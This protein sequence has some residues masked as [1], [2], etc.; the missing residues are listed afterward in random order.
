M[1]SHLSILLGVQWELIFI[2]IRTSRQALPLSAVCLP[3][4]RSVLTYDGRL[5]WSRSV[6]R[7][8]AVAA[9]SSMP[10]WSMPMA[11]GTPGLA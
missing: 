3:V 10:L 2:S 1:L 6:M 7:R 11:F 5:G 4:K 9:G 8:V